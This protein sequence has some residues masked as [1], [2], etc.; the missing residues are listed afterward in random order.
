MPIWRLQ[1][2]ISMDST[3]PRDVL[4]MT[5]HFNDQG[6]GT[7]PQGLCDDLAAAI[8][9]WMDSRVAQITVTAYDAQGTVPVFPQGRAQVNPGAAPASDYPR[10]VAVCLSFYSERNRPRFRGRL[11]VPF[12]ALS[13]LS[14]NMGARP[15]VGVRNRVALL[16]PIFQDLGGVDVDW[17]VYSRVDDEARPVTNWWVDDEWDTVR[18]RGLRPTTRTA[19]TT[20][21][22]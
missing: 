22:G 12:V 14:Q 18:S 9:T 3:L 1:T 2:E 4:T 5:P 15:P 21:E 8:A 11:Y 13:P 6:A 20:S 10:E 16:A 17:C 7:D 19:G